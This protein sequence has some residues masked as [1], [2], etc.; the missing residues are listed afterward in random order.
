M[1]RS[2]C[3][4][5]LYAYNKGRGVATTGIYR[6][7]HTFAKQWI[8]SGGNVVALSRMLGHS[9]LSITQNYVNLLVSDLAKQVEEINLLDR[10][11]VRQYRKSVR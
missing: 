1:Q 3:Y 6:Y 8:L 10:F 5:M 4:G 7:R 2:T 11:V 9:D